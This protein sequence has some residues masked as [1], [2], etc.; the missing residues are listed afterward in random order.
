MVIYKDTKRASENIQHPFMIQTLRELEENFFS[1]KSTCMDNLKIMLHG[2]TLNFPSLILET[3]QGYP[4]FP[5]LFNSIPEVL[6]SAIK[7]EKEI[8][9]INIGKIKLVTSTAT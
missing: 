3:R 5:L 9:D 4:L 6:V 2:E 7:P 1:L 8:R